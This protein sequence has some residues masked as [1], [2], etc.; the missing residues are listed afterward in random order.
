MQGPASFV[1]L[2]AQTIIISGTATNSGMFEY[3]GVPGPGNP[4]LFAVVAPGVT[5]DPYGNSLSG[6]DVLIQGQIIT[7]S[8]GIIRTNAT[9]PL[10]QLDGPHDS[11][12]VYDASANLVDTIAPV[13]TNDGLGNVVVAGTASYV[14]I[15]GTRYAIILGSAGNGFSGTLP[16][17]TFKN[18][19][20]PFNID[21]T[22]GVV[23]L[24]GAAGNSAISISSGL[25]NAGGQQSNIFLQDSVGSGVTGGFLEA[26]AGSMEFLIDIAGTYDLAAIMSSDGTRP[27]TA[28]S[29]I[30]LD[31]INTTPPANAAGPVLAGNQGGSPVIVNTSGLFRL[32]SGA[33]ASDFTAFT[34]T[35]TTPTV[36]TKV[37]TIPANDAIAGARYKLTAKGFGTQGTTAENLVYT[38]VFGTLTPAQ[39]AFPAAFAGVSIGFRWWAEMDMECVSTGSGATWWVYLRVTI[40]FN[41]ANTI[42]STSTGGN[43][44]AVTQSTLAAIHVSLES[45]W[46]SAGVA[47]TMSTVSSSFERIA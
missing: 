40:G 24:G 45:A 36:I 16:A 1:V 26:S 12:F 25:A 47:A 6:I 46:S 30:V 18:L 22:V 11:I 13:A 4:P 3:S 43:S 27:F 8:Q 14:I 32:I 21:P 44:L 33:A 7:M 39:A 29:Y 28:F 31:A 35:N 15:S 37:Y 41:G 23:G 20:T 42:G 5:T 9:A 17:L 38:G 19:T 10:I 2:E 34:S